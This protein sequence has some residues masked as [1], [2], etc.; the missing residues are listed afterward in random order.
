MKVEVT[1][2]SALRCVSHHNDE[3]SGW[4][5]GRH[6]ASARA[7]LKSSSLPYHSPSLQPPSKVSTKFNLYIFQVKYK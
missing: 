4:P 1:D 6:K 2:Q 7:P 5:T 3:S